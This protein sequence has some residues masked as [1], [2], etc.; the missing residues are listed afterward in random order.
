ML[1]M[2]IGCLTHLMERG[3]A[4]HLSRAGLGDALDG[5]DDRGPA[6]TGVLLHKGR[7]HGRPE[8]TRPRRSRGWVPAFLTA[9]PPR[10]SQ[11]P[12]HHRGTWYHELQPPPRSAA[13][14]SSP[15][16]HSSRQN[17]ARGQCPD[18]PSPEGLAS[19]GKGSGGLLG[20]GSRCPG[21]RP[22]GSYPPAWRI[23]PAFC[24][25]RASPANRLLAA[26]N[27]LTPPRAD[28]GAGRRGLPRPRP[29]EVPR[30][31][32]ARSSA[33]RREAAPR[34]LECSHRLHGPPSPGSP[35]SYSPSSGT[36]DR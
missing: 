36:E 27:G 11:S 21:T 1:K 18:Q 4:R 25:P 35:G 15:T 30:A 9:A 3:A 33:R 26:L 23:C 16:T 22:P 32:P 6:C 5:Q 28:H 34:S 20:V 7:Q 2:L 31:T 17:A 8:P 24:G 19:V 10:A 13:P 14:G 12:P 29:L